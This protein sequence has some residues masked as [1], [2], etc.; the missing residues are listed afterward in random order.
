MTK[1]LIV[2]AMLAALPGAVAAEQKK[3]DGKAQA[4]EAAGDNY[5]VLVARYLET[6]RQTAGA[7]PPAA[8]RRH[9][10]P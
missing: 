8:A 4:G 6:A 2:A 5:D 7:A 3:E 10:T 1:V 9:P